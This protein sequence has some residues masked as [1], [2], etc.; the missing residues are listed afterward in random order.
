MGDCK[1]VGKIKHNPYYCTQDGQSVFVFL[2]Y[3][4]NFHEVFYISVFDNGTKTVN[5]KIFIPSPRS[6]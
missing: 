4:K 6:T 2:V 5:I 1:R 3:Y